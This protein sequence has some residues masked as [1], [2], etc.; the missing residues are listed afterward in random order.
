VGG[1][2]GVVAGGAGGAGGE[3]DG[4]WGRSSV[5]PSLYASLPRVQANKL[6]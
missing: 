1:V 5:H 4:G 2:G 6:I 3:D